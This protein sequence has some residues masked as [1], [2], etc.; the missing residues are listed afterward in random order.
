MTVPAQP[1]LKVGGQLNPRRHLYITRADLEERVYS[2]LASGEYCNILSSRQFG[3]SSLMNKVGLRLRGEG[4]RVVA[5]DI[6]GNLGSPPDATSWYQ[7]LVKQ[8]SL[9]LKL[10]LDVQAWWAAATGI[11]DNERLIEFFGV[12]LFRG[13][14]EPL[15]I[16]LDEIDHTLE[17]PYT[18]DFFTAIRAMYNQRGANP[19]YE[20]VCFCLVG[21]ATPNELVKRRRTTAF[22]VGITVPLRDFDAAQDDLSPLRDALAGGGAGGGR[23]GETLLQ[24]VLEWTGGHPFLTLQLCRDCL[25]RDLGNPAAVD[26]FAR[27]RFASYGKVSA[28]DHFQL[29]ARFLDERLSNQLST[30]KLYQRIT[31]G[32]EV[33]DS[34]ARQ[35]IELKLAGLVRRDSHGLLRVRNRIYQQVFDRDWVRSSKPQRMQRY[36]IGFSAAA[37][38]LLLAASLWIGYDQLVLK[39]ERA[40]I[41]HLISEIDAT[42]E[43]ED[44]ERDAAILAGKDPDPVL[45]RPIRGQAQ[46]AKDAL[47]RFWTRK[48]QAVGERWLATLEATLDE[49]QADTA[50][51]ILT[52]QLDAPEL[53]MPIRKGFEE[54]AQAGH[55]EFKR[56][57]EESIAQKHLDKLRETSDEKRAEELFQVLSGQRAP[58]ELR[59]PIRG[60]EAEALET[61]RAFWLRRAAKLDELALT[62]LEAGEKD[63]AL[64]QAAA[65]ALKRGGELDESYR[66]VYVELGYGRLYRT[67]RSEESYAGWCEVAISPDSRLVADGMGG[68]WESKSGRLLRRVDSN[69]G[70]GVAFSPDGERLALGG[71]DNQVRVWTVDDWALEATLPVDAGGSIYEVAFSPDGSR[72][73]ASAEMDPGKMFVWNT[74]TW[75]LDFK[76]ED[77]GMFPLG[78]CFVGDSERLATA[79]SS[80]V[81]LWSLEDGE[82]VDLRSSRSRDVIA[83]GTGSNLVFFDHSDGSIRISTLSDGQSRVVP[84]DA[85][86]SFA[87][88]WSPDGRYLLESR[89]DSARVIDIES[90]PPRT[91][92]Q[93]RAHGESADVNDGHFSSDGR[94]AVTLGTDGTIRVWDLA[95]LGS[96]PPGFP[97]GDPAQV[98]A[99]LQQVLGLTLDDNDQVVPLWPQGYRPPK[100]WDPG[101][102]EQFAN[103]DDNSEPAA[104]DQR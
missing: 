18:D 36:L 66:D 38:V 84:S 96:E 86:T 43:V 16:F 19:A 93:T 27:D 55:T 63:Q 74:T 54:R 79:S 48:E 67:M 56:R 73:A 34:P 83:N 32:R 25:E 68:V 72:L 99:H 21:V 23:D 49:Q 97:T 11:T 10:D 46:A 64:I 57:Y 15:V 28:E 14:D 24:A 39:P 104:G 101:L 22:N 70:I 44:A 77:F 31:E 59:Q 61:Y 58:I 17:L 5:I 41:E 30:L 52:G 8:V 102:V 37:A 35:V 6:A 62:R 26:A 92:F 2:L 90:D 88:D 69:H 94:L 76:A 81:R 95:D 4:V 3:K 89:T 13:Q 53:R 85:S 12:E 103:P 42:L 51:A 91:V 100:G 40:R 47:K 33:A 45:G 98:W 87:I 60:F 80:G 78:V 71:S 75:G 65:A 9:Q 29:I 1:E 50:Y 20:R 7:G 82:T